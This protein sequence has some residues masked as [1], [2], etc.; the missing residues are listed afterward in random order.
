MATV[1]KLV[2][3]SALQLIEL[4]LPT[5]FVFPPALAQTASAQKNQIVTVTA[6]VGAALLNTLSLMHEQS[7]PTV[8]IADSV[9]ILMMTNFSTTFAFTLEIAS[10]WLSLLVILTSVSRGN[11]VDK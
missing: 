1:L 11:E 7:T 10:K 3:M 6:E 5:A 8:F 9:D 2:H 4:A